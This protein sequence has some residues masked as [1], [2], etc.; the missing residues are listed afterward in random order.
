MQ[1]DYERDTSFHFN[2]RLDRD[3]LQM[4][5]EGDLS[6]A[7]DIFEIFLAHSIN[8]MDELGSAIENQDWEATRRISHKLKPNFSMVGLPQLEQK[9]GQIEMCAN[10]QNNVEIIAGI[11]ENLKS[12]LTTFIP[13]LKEDLERIRHV[14]TNLV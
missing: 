5:Y 6:Y 8:E 4:V 1:D 14:K 10:L 7:G 12:S 13:V 2:E 3:F 11:Y 9:M